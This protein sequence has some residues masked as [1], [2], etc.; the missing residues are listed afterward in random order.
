MTIIERAIDFAV[1]AH[2]GTK[3]KGK[4]T[5]YILHPIEVMTI[6]ASMTNDEEV[7]AAAVLHDTVED[8]AVTKEDIVQTFGERI[9]ALVMA[10]SE[11]KMETLPATSTWQ[12]RKQATID[13]RETLDRDLNERMAREGLRL[14]HGKSEEALLVRRR[15]VKQ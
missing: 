5:P 11:D 9:A 6:V 15:T 12:Q 10:E 1:K 2:E 14:R 7:I 4:E 13:H 8:T 3:R